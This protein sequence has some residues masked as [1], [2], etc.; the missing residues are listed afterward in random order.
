MSRTP[1]R[2]CATVPLLRSC[3]VRK[4]ESGTIINYCQADETDGTCD[5][6][7]T[8]DEYASFAGLGPTGA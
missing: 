8:A 2:L 4:D 1:P 5:S 6:C 3:R 7:Y